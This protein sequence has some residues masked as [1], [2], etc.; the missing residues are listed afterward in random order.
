MSSTTALKVY[1]ASMSSIAPVLPGAAIF[2]GIGVGI[3]ASARQSYPVMNLVVGILII[4]FSLWPA[5]TVSTNRLIVTRA[6]WFTGITCAVG[7]SG[8]PRSG[9]RG[10]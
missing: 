3:T 5:I 8:G 10:R 4:L 7:S 9:R 2:L 1:R 6:D